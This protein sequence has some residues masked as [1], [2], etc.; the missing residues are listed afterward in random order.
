MN[1]KN[2][3]ISK[4]LRPQAQD[5]SPKPATKPTPQPTSNKTRTRTGRI[6]LENFYVKNPEEIADEPYIVTYSIRAKVG[7]GTPRIYMNRASGGPGS[8]SPGD[9]WGRRDASQSIPT[10]VGQLSFDNLQDYEIYGTYLVILEE[11]ATSND[12]RRKFFLAVEKEIAD[13]F[14]KEF[15]SLTNLTGTHQEKLFKTL[16]ALDKSVNQLG[17]FDYDTDGFRP[18][19]NQFTKAGVNDDDYIG[20]GGIF[21]V[22]IPSNQT[23]PKDLQDY[24]QNRR[25]SPWCCSPKLVYNESGDFEKFY[26]YLKKYEQRAARQLAA[27]AFQFGR[28]KYNISFRHEEFT[29]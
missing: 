27:T 9:N 1:E 7:R 26:N 11:D 28:T 3:R 12:N 23:M 22:A 24:Y 21:S 5:T 2:N 29:Q 17:T 10:K 20:D 6:T 25:R 14:K 8:L 4:A 13:V 19:F 15:S 16:R 18:L